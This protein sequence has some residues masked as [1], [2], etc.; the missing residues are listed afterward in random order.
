MNI[1]K[2][3]FDVEHHLRMAVGFRWGIVVD[4]AMA[5]LGEVSVT[6]DGD[7]QTILQHTSIVGHLRYRRNHED[8]N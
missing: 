6:F 2:S 5:V 8:R 7:V 4:A 1:G 3:S